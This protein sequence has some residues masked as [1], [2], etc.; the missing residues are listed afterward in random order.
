M[1]RKSR[2]KVSSGGGNL[3]SEISDSKTQGL[4]Y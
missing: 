2:P 3:N 4:F 1:G